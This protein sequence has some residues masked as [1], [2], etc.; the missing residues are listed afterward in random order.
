MPHAIIVG[1][2]I[3]GLSIAAGFRRRKW[4]V[5][6]LEQGDVPFE[7]GSS[8]DDHRLIRI[9]Y[10]TQ[11]GYARM[12]IDALRAWEV[13]WRELGV[14]HYAKTGILALAESKSNPHSCWARNSRRILE[15]LNVSCEWIEGTAITERWPLIIDPDN[16]SALY[17]SDGGVLFA[18][19]IVTDWAD[20]LSANG[21]DLRTHTR[22]QNINSEERSVNLANGE[23]LTGD[24]LVVAAGPWING[25]VP[26]LATR[27]IPSRQVVAYLDPPEELKSL[28]ENSP[29]IIDV[30]RADGFYLVPP[31]SGLKMKIA[32]HSFS[33]MGNPNERSIAAGE[34]QQIVATCAARLRDF[35]RYRLLEGRVCFYTVT[36]DEKFIAEPL[37]T[38]ARPQ[39]WVISACSG[40]G[41]KFAPLL[42][43]HLVD[44]I[45]NGKDPVRFMRWA[46]GDSH[47]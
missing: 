12:A 32:D 13:V 37:S 19:R 5:T 1:A 30:D 22:V 40:H 33:R 14:R 23:R 10:G 26:E 43:D 41:F 39:S 46:S 6:L 17:T 16:L 38:E 35:S 28:W 21:T 25:L 4:D 9:P 8:V 2:G 3:Y 36:A 15:K 44:E 47:V 27:L 34:V 7:K 20:H 45:V 29:A 42:G 18:R 31:G 11:E 24:A